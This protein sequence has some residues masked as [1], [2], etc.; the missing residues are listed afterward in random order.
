LKLC[1]CKNSKICGIS[2][3]WFCRNQ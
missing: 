3:I 1:T 2:I